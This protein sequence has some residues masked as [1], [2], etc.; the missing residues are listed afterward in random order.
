M[1][2]TS[3]LIDSNPA[4]L[5]ELAQKAYINGDTEKAEMLSTIAEL[6]TLNETLEEKA[7]ELESLEKKTEDFKAY[8]GFFEDCFLRLNGR[9]PCPS[10]TSDYDCNVIFEAIEK[11]ETE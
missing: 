8:K 5:E 11:G 1:L 2:T 7:D 9:Y 3:D 4:F 6:I 10:V